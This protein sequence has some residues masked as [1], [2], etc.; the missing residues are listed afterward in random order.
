VS[1][2][3]TVTGGDFFIVDNSDEAWKAGGWPGAFQAAAPA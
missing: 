2:K 1:K 3:T